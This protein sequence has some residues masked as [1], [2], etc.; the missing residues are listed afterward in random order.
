MALL[1]KWRDH[2][3]GHFPE[4]HGRE[5]IRQL[6]SSFRTVLTSPCQSQ[7]AP[8]QDRGHGKPLNCQRG[9]TNTENQCPPKSLGS[10][11]ASALRPPAFSP[12]H[13]L[14]PHPLIQSFIHLTSEPLTLNINTSPQKADM[15]DL[16]S[17]TGRDVGAAGGWSHSRVTL[18]FLLSASDVRHSSSLLITRRFV[19]LVRRP[20]SVATATGSKQAF[21]LESV[22]RRK[23]AQKFLSEGFVFFPLCLFL[24]L[25]F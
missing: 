9:R 16:L 13:S 7:F 2:W 20:F 1:P 4:G 14:D 12:S 22:K 25:R 21:L 23:I 3:E 15:P 11:Q 19:S 18:R 10:C 17:G 8:E 6:G 24:S 5:P